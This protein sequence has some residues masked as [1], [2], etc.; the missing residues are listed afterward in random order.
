MVMDA[1]DIFVRHEN[2][3]TGYYALSCLRGCGS[4][5]IETATVRQ[6]WLTPSCLTDLSGASFLGNLIFLLILTL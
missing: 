2:G 3:G 5:K 6:L 4:I 1:P